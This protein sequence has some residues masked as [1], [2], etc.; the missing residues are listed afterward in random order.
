MTMLTGQNYPIGVCPAMRHVLH[1]FI[2]DG[3]S[4]RYI[5]FVISD[6]FEYDKTAPGPASGARCDIAEFSVLG[7]E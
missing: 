6:A 1:S 2:Q 4:A 3:S 5:R 7:E